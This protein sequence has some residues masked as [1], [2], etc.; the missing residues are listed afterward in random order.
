VAAGDEP[1]AQPGTKA[2]RHETA[3]SQ[4]YALGMRRIAQAAGAVVLLLGIFWT[5]RESTHGIAAFWE[6]WWCPIPLVLALAGLVAVLITRRRPSS[7]S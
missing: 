4:R 1:A 2:V 7:T 6:H 3:R 5:G